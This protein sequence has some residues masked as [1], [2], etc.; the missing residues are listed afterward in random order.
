MKRILLIGY[1][2]SDI[3]RL[4]KLLPKI[5]CDAFVLAG[6]VPASTPLS[7]ST[8][9]PNSFDAEP[10]VISKPKVYEEDSFIRTKEF[11]ERSESKFFKNN[12]RN[13]KTR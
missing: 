9:K 4:T 11:Y 10:L 6:S 7:I 8:E 12:K 5:E 2:G 1:I 13:Y 3:Q